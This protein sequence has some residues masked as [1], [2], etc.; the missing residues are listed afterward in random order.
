MT[1]LRLTLAI[2]DY[3]RTRALA[4]GRVAPEG[5]DLTVLNLPVEEIFSF[6]YGYSQ[7]L[8]DARGLSPAAA[9]LIVLPTFTIGVAVAA[10]TGRRAEVRAKLLVGSIAQIVA[11][12]LIFLMPD[13]A[14]VWALLLP[15]AVL[16]LPQGLNNLA[17][18]N[19]LYFQ[20]DPARIASSAG[21]QRTFMYL[22]AISA[23]VAIG[24]FYGDRATTPGIHGLGL[25]VLCV[26]VVFLGLVAFDRSLARV[27]RAAG[28]GKE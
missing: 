26:A 27:G 17:N 16:G 11:G 4:D 15:A 25:F 3:D 6:S 22:G 2:G 14:P 1:K 8:Q 10:L 7:W 9:G 19:A 28:G 20:A 12:A 24:L 13:D 21:L 23:S 18:Q 5:V